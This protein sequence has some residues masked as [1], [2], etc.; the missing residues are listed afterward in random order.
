MFS[1]VRLKIVGSNKLLTIHLLNSYLFYFLIIGH[2]LYIPLL[3]AIEYNKIIKNTSLKPPS[4]QRIKWITLFVEYDRNLNSN[5]DL[6]EIRNKSLT[7]LETILTL[8]SSFN[9]RDSHTF[10][11]FIPYT[12]KLKH[13]CTQY[14]G[15]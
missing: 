14:K 4:S 7:F 9:S 10:F 12:H 13:M 2:C 5:G 6:K 11:L 8:H 1:V 3:V 15:R